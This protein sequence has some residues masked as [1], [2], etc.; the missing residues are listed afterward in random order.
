MTALVIGTGRAV[1]VL[2]DRGPAAPVG[3]DRWTGGSG[4]LIGGRL[5]LTVAHNVDYRQDPGDGGQLLVRTMEGSEFAARVVLVC[6]EPSRVDL[7]L[8]EISAPQFDEHLPAVSFARVNRD[9]PAPVPSCWAV[10]FPQFGEAGPVLPE[11]SKKETWEVGGYILPGTKLRAGL[12]SLQVTSTP[13]P[14]PASLRGSEWEGMSGTAVFATDPDEGELAVGIVSMHNPPEGESA[15]TVVPVTAVAGLQVVADHW[16]HRLGVTDPGALPVLPRQASPVG[17][18][19]RPGRDSAAAG[20]PLGEVTDP[21]ALEVHRPVQ[22]EDPQPGLPALPAYVPREHDTKLGSVVRA[23]AEGSSG[24]A[25]LVGGPSTGKTRACWEALLLLR[26]QDPGWRLWHPIDPDAALRELPAVG[27]RTVVWLNEAQRYL[28]VADVGLG[29]R[30]AAGLRELLRDPARAPV[31]VLA[32]LWFEFWG[33]LTARPAGVADP[34]AQARELLDGQGITM[35]KAFT[36]AELQRLGETGDPRLAEAAAA[37]DGQVIQFLAGAPEL[38]ARYRNAPPAAAALINAA[39]DARRLGMGIGLP[40][41]FLETAAPGYLTDDEWDAQDEHWLEQ[42]LVYTAVPCK[43]VRGPLTRI[44]PHAAS[45]RVPG[46]GSQNGDKQ[47]A[48]GQASIAGVPQYRL[49]DYLEQHGRH[50]RKSQIPLADFWAAAA[51]QAVPGDQ[52]ALGDAAHARGLYRDAAQLH[53]NAAANGNLHAVFYLANPPH[54]L[55]NDIHPV[56]WAIEHVPLDDPHGV[57]ALLD[58]LQEAGAQDQVTALAKRAAARVTLADP[59]AVAVLL[60]SLQEAGAQDQVTALAKRAAA[61]VTLA[62]PGA[63]AVLL[64]SLR[65]AGAQ[66]QVTALAKR[67]AAQ[68]TLA[69]PGGVAV[70]LDW[71]RE[72]GAQ[73]QVT[74]LLD[75]APA[76][77]VTFADPRGVAVLLDWLREAGAQG[78]V[79]ALLDRA[80]AAQV[81]LADPAGVDMLLRSLREAGGQDQVTALA[82]RAAKDIPVASPV[83]V[84]VLLRSLR[85]AGAQDQVTALA[86]RAAAQ[87][88]LADP[89][90]VAMLLG[91][92]QEAGAQEQAA[93]LLDRAPAD[94]VALADPAGVDMLLG[95][96]PPDQAAT[97]AERAAKDIPVASPVGF[98]RL[99]SSLPPDQATALAEGTAVQVVRANPG[100]VA[101]LLYSLREAGAQD[102]ATALAERAAAQAPLTNPFDVVSLLDQL[103]KAGAQ[104]QVTALAKRAANQVALD[105]PRGVAALLDQLQDAGAQDQVTALAKRAANQVALDDP[106]GVAAL[107]DHLRWA[108]AQDQ[109]TV[110]LDRAPADQVALA[111]PA[112]VDM[113]LG[114]LR[115][116]GDQDQVALLVDRLPGEGLFELFSGQGNNQALYQFGRNADGSPAEPWGWE[117]LE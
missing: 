29:E 68:V 1:E 27:P 25:V 51:N 28:D 107:L 40:Q 108:G 92:L 39:I 60:G 43:G 13:R 36:V 6:D 82:E 86:E 76:A 101:M 66:D 104:D 23:A 78:Q 114:S 62:D 11:G 32:T 112:G 81:T 110:L 45:S 37:L 75:R 72:A 59:G 16:W 19:Q 73:G 88:T 106:R 30:V 58:R 98:A 10:G 9:S 4:Y 113:L 95:S 34:H 99:L 115:E 87:V 61:R 91:W 42:A 41:A 79:T 103:Q 84:V 12:L 97:L 50:E 94:Q 96:L 22:P 83:G 55:R 38:L 24:I 65:D 53:K 33:G 70:L 67:A 18:R 46:P 3:V 64:G 15:L 85:E 71:L 8:L 31:L 105:D 14:L 111:D 26:D 21:F 74:A 20:R 56:R 100:R 90:G 35:P 48:G 102:Q 54:Y 2:H 7:A 77:Q 49:A 44:R 80:P 5:V 47:P 109:V 17:G 117:G 63:V 93:E 57:A 116:A 52:A 69:D 89:R